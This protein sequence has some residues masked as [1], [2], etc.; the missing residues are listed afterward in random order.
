[1]SQCP[2]VIMSPCLHCQCVS[3]SQDVMSELGAGCRVCLHCLQSAVKLCQLSQ[4]S[5]ATPA[6][7]WTEPDL[8][9]WHTNT[10]QSAHY[11]QPPDNLLLNTA[12]GPLVI[13][14]PI[15][16]LPNPK[17]KVCPRTNEYHYRLWPS[18]HSSSPC[19]VMCCACDVLC[20]WCYA[21]CYY[22]D[23]QF[24]VQL[25]NECNHELDNSHV[26]M[27]RL[28]SIAQLHI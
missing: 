22:Y 5:A 21:K 18:R 4:I 23:D 28:S 1:M 13:G 26:N 2:H 16:N 12:A 8:T 25:M 6:P 3:M 20:M 9:P 7:D 15:C 14:R 11:I 24:S 27:S 17:I 10:V 19:D